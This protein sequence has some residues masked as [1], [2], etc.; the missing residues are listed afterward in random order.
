MLCSLVLVIG[1]FDFPT[2]P[3]AMLLG[4]ISDSNVLRKTITESI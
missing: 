4:G 1:K 3:A 2:Y